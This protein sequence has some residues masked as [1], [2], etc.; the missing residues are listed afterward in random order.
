[1]GFF[2]GSDASIKTVPLSKTQKQAR[3]YIEQLLAGG[4]PD[5]PTRGIAGMSDA[6]SQAQTILQRYLSG[7]PEG[8]DEGMEHLRGT[9]AGGYD[10]R[11]SQYYQGLREQS[12]MDE[13]DAVAAL[14]RGSQAGGMF[15][16]DPSMRAEGTLRSRYGASRDALLGGLYRDDLKRRDAAVPQL[17][18]YGQMPAMQAAQG[19][20]LGGLPRQ[21]AQAGENANYQ[22][23][24][25]RV[26][27]P[28]THGS[29]L[30]GQ[31][32]DMKADTYMTPGG[33]SEM[34]QWFDA[35][36]YVSDMGNPL[37]AMDGFGSN[38]ATNRQ[39][40]GGGGGGGGLGS[41][42]GILGMML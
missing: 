12:A 34:S 13:A 39:A 24:L 15:Y 18:R 22:T 16:S 33:P 20:Q 37:I 3:T 25:Q 42:A 7:A 28:Y 32:F 19:M 29:N 35:A 17:M 11:T 1:M 41:L 21:L 30:A 38:M 2:S 23:L 10:P 5:M 8:Y 14:R 26:M 40:G 6:E 31:L 36:G 9:L 4:T 27:F